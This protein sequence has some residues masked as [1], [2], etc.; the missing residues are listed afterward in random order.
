MCLSCHSVAT[1]SGITTRIGPIAGGT[2]LTVTGSAF[3]DVETLYCQF[4][5]SRVRAIYIS[6]TR[7][8]CI[9]PTS[10]SAGAVTVQVSNN[11]VEFVGAPTFTYIGMLLA[12]LPLSLSVST[13]LCI[14]I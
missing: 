14:R 7:V 10:G 5:S 1:L 11:N 2:R 6:T 13:N 8:F 3:A 12:C 4:G 9:A